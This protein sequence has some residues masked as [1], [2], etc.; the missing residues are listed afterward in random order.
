MPRTPNTP[1]D[2]LFHAL[3][4][5]DGRAERLLRDLL[6]DAAGDRL[7]DAP[8]E[9]LPGSFIDDDLR[10]HQTDGLFRARLTDGTPVSIYVLCEH[11]SHLSPDLPVQLLRYMT[12][13]WSRHMETEDSRPGVLAPVIPVLVYHGGTPWTWPRSI[14][15]MIEAPE[16]L[17]DF[18]QRL[19]LVLCDLG[20]IGTDAL[21]GDAETRA[22]L[23]ALRHARDRPVAD[24]A[25][26]AILSGARAGSALELQILA[27]IVGVYELDRERLEAALRAARPERWRMLMGT[28][29]EELIREGE[30]RGKERGKAEGRAEGKAE[31]R[32]EGKAEGRAETLLGLLRRRFGGLDAETEARIGSASVAELDG[33]L[34]AVLDGESL[35]D[36]LAAPPRNAP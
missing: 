16:P 8:I 35:G 34:D 15:E 14:A 19:S 25:L 21:P 10:R 3:I 5:D 23:A 1:H 20:R 24:E 31:G 4:G 13:I 12:R 30:Q 18:V 17:R 36:V 32:A 7:A 11:K 26:R 29:A 22:G 33:W 6:R 9:R 27:Y 2:R 28:V